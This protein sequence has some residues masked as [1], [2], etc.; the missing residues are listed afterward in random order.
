MSYTIKH[1]FDVVITKNPI[2]SGGLRPCFRDSYTCVQTPSQKIL[3]PPLTTI[4]LLESLRVLECRKNHG[5]AR[6]SVAH[7]GRVI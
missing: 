7:P 2:A 1:N 6:G 4:H 5:L 3:D